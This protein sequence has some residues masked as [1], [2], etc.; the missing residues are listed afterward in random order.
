VVPQALAKTLCAKGDAMLT[1]EALQKHLGHVQQSYIEFMLS[2]LA[3]W[4]AWAEASSRME[5]GQAVDKNAIDPFF[6]TEYE[7]VKIV[8]EMEDQGAFDWHNPRLAQLFAAAAQSEFYRFWGDQITDIALQIAGLA[9]VRTLLEA[10]AGRG[11]LT[12]RM[13]DKLAGRGVDLPLIVTDAH[14]AVLE[15]VESLRGQFPGVRQET[16]LWD[17]SAPPSPELAQLCTPPVLLYERASL[18]YANYRAIE[19]LGRVADIV[20]LG[21]YFNYTGELYGY[22]RVSARVGVKPLLYREALP[23]LEQS[24]PHTWVFDREVPEKLGVPNISLIIAWK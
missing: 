22:D 13:L 16:R 5:A 17:F 4:K 19:N 11:N 8:L 3:G 1:R 14:P 18:T 7:W 10:G 2:H 24:F 23:V 6:H 21:D 15:R 12:A 9:G 20:V